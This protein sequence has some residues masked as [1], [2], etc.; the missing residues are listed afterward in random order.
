VP[1]TGF[2]LGQ[3]FGGF[4]WVVMKG[5]VIADTTE[6]ELNIFLAKLFF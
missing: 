1:I 2:P 6:P 4:S 5:T 3:P